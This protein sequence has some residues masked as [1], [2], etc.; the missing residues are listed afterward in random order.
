MAE[1]NPRP[2]AGSMTRTKHLQGGS[3][4]DSST[5]L[6]ALVGSQA[7]VR[8]GTSVRE[9]AIRVF[10]ADDHAI[11]REGVK[12]LL[13]TAPDIE[14]VG[15]ADDGATAVASSQRLKPAVLILDLDMP[16]MDGATTLREARATLPSLRVLILTMHAE[17]EHLLR[18]LESGAHGYLSKAATSRDLVEAIRVV[19][20]GEIYVRPVAARMLARAVVSH[21]QPESAPARYK[22][23]SSREQTVLR[24]VAVGYS[25]VETARELAV[26]TKTVDAYKRRICDKLGLTH[27]TEYVRFAV[28]AGLLGS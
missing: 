5:R 25:G 10:L 6:G 20:S 4:P 12:A 13:R 2:F 22:A 17:D 3:P 16:R 23:L 15:E 9:E 11:F 8:R 14:V 7:Y 1:Y 28:E 24:L 21:I 27:R 18:L 19:A 26:S